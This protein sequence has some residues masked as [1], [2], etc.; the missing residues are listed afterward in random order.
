MYYLKIS[1]ITSADHKV[2]AGSPEEP[3]HHGD[4]SDHVQ[5]GDE[6]PEHQDEDT[7]LPVKLCHVFR[8]L[9]LKEDETES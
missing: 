3:D 8:I 7:G 5:G 9:K 4:V 6:D 1:L 2:R